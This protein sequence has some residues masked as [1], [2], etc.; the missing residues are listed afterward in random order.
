M[1][2]RCHCFNTL[3]QH[4]IEIINEKKMEDEPTDA[5]QPVQSHRL[6]GPP[7]HWILLQHL[8]EVIHRQRVEAAVVVGPHAGRPPASGQQAD[9]CTDRKTQGHSPQ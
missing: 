8:V 7:H 9:L 5:V 1:L 6:E 3:P 4:Y 2:K